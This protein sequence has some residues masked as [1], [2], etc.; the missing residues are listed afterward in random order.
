MEIE[1]NGERNVK[2]LTENFLS[3]LWI[4]SE[5]Y[6]VK[7]LKDHIFMKRSHF[8]DSKSAFFKFI[9]KIS[10]SYLYLFLV[11]HKTL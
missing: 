9:D 4:K 5:S 10:Y 8:H 3:K 2:Q 6:F 1:P 7:E 11:T